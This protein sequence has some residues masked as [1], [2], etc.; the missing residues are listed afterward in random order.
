MNRWI[1][2]ALGGA[3]IGCASV[4]PGVSGG[5]IAVALGIYREIIDALSYRSICANIRKT[6]L[7]F[8]TLA[9]GALL[10]VLLVA[11]I[12]GAVLER[13][14]LLGVAFFIG[15][16]IGSIPHIFRSY[17]THI[18]RWYDMLIFI[19]GL[20]MVA[21]PKLLNVHIDEVSVAAEEV[22][23]FLL[24]VSGMVASAAMVL[25]GIS[26]SLTLLMFGTYAYILEAINTINISVLAI[27]ACAAGVGAL[28]CA[29][30]MRELFKRMPRHTWAFI[31]GLVVGSIVFLWPQIPDTPHDVLLMVGLCV[32]GS[33]SSY[34]LSCKN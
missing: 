12:M 10:G 30:M 3:G 14:P 28:L 16:I 33:A 7:F 32:V 19:I 17:C 21:L 18:R 25:P 6:L 20:G 1:K 31:L 8:G 23:I 13:F 24:V 27:F 11:R 5:T 29:K 34:V 2:Y 22:S 26:G 9:C 4:V 15:L